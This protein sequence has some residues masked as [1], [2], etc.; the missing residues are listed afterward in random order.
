MVDCTQGAF[1]PIFHP[2][3]VADEGAVH[4]GRRFRPVGFPIT[5]EP[6]PRDT[7]FA[8]STRVLTGTKVRSAR[9]SFLVSRP[10]AVFFPRVAATFG[11]GRSAWG[12]SAF[13][14][15]EG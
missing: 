12:V 8:E 11:E 13:G 9:P 4:E 15:S 3:V 10:P 14:R 2:H 7:F 6:D 1:H 5:E